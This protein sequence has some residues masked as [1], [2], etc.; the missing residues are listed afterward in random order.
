MFMA[1]ETVSMRV[2]TLWTT[3]VQCSCK[4]PAFLCLQ[5]AISSVTLVLRTTSPVSEDQM[6][7]QAI[8]RIVDGYERLKGS[9]TKAKAKAKIK[10]ERMVGGASALVGGAL[11][12]Y[13]DGKFRDDDG[14]TKHVLGVP[15]IAGASALAAVAGISEL[16]PGGMYLGMAG[17]GGLAYVVGKAMYER[18]AAKK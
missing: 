2:Y 9:I 13:A 4:K 15:A 16:V 8:T 3:A 6:A 12:G 17:V 7:T 11:A 1:L 10:G 14:G 18:G 5:L